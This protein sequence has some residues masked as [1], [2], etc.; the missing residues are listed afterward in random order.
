MTKKILIKTFGKKLE[1]YGF[2]YKSY[3]SFRWTFSRMEG[4]VEHFIVFQRD[5]LGEKKFRIEISTSA[6][7]NIDKKC[8]KLFGD[9]MLEK[10]YTDEGLEP[11]L[12]E[13]GDEVIEK[14]LP[15]FPELS[16]PVYTYWDTHEMHKRLYQ[17]KEKHIESFLVRHELTY[18]DAADDV[19]VCLMRE[20]NE[21]VG[22]PFLEI[23]DKLIELGA[24]YG[25]IVILIL[26]GKWV[27]RD[28]AAIGE[29]PQHLQPRLGREMNVLR[30]LTCYCQVP[31]NNSLIVDYVQ[32]K[33]NQAK[34]IRAQKEEYGDSLILP[35]LRKYSVEEK[36]FHKAIYNKYLSPQLLQ[37]GF[38]PF[39]EEETFWFL[40]K[41]IGEKEYRLL[42]KADEWE[43]NAISARLYSSEKDDKEGKYCIFREYYF[44]NSEEELIK[45]LMGLEMK[46]AQAVKE[47]KKLYYRYS[48]EFGKY[49]PTDEMRLMYYDLVEENLAK[50][51][52]GKTGKLEENSMISQLQERLDKIQGLGYEE[53]KDEIT[54]VSAE[55][56]CI[57]SDNTKGE[58]EL[59]KGKRYFWSYATDIRIRLLFVIVDCWERKKDLMQIYKD[60][61]EPYREWVRLS[62]LCCGEEWEPYY[63]EVE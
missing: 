35:K 42:I 37:Q 24:V 15:K 7:G 46:I 29:K 25:Y 30:P 61:I 43:R 23:E 40:S 16:I 4:E 54:K 53:A 5:L 55:F 10:K 39:A 48:R 20:L 38:K 33:R 51:Q 13:L 44:Y 9:L 41:M 28:E 21:M 47:N 12:E 57:L 14:V 58:W 2:H 34:W 32:Y 45:I 18:E 1:P 22:K 52:N 3:V 31:G 49:R 26:G 50:R 19:F 6:C 63:I 11:L 27:Y 36:Y 17:E 56:V 59:Y 62:K 60:Y 8:S